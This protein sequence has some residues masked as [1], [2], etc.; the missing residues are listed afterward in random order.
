MGDIS[1]SKAVRSNL[2]SLQNTSAMMTKTQERLSTGNKVNSALDNPTN[3]FTAAGLNSRAGDMNQLLDSM[4][5]GI[6]TLEAAD[7]GLSAIT[8]TLESMQSTLR[9]A[10]Q[11]KTF[12]T[13]SFALADARAGELTFAGGSLT[14]DVSIALTDASQASIIGGADYAVGQSQ[15]GVDFTFAAADFDDAGDTISFDLNIDGVT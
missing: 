7:N 2:L 14:N 1:L 13:K 5:S 12:E 3:F 8:K 4:A 6:Q 10:R 11:D 15:G 9:Q